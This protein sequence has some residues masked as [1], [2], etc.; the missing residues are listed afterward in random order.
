M[1]ATRPPLISEGSVIDGRFELLRLVGQGGFATVYE[2]RQ[3]NIGRKVAVKV[4]SLQH[5]LRPEQMDG[6]KERFVQ[7]ARAA[8]GIHHPDIVTIHDY[9]VVDQQP[10]IV[11]ELLQGHDLGQEIELHGALSPARAIPLFIRCLDALQAAHDQTIVHKDLKPSNLFLTD[12]GSMVETLRILDFGIA[13]VLDPDDGESGRMTKTGEYVGTAMYCAPEYYD[14]GTVSPALDVYQMGLILAE[15]LTGRAVVDDRPVRAIMRH[16]DGDV[17]CP[18]ELRGSPIEPLIDRAMARQPRDRFPNAGAFRDA[19]A[20]INA[21][22]IP[23][24]AGAGIVSTEAPT[25]DE[26]AALRRRQAPRQPTGQPSTGSTRPAARMAVPGTPTQPAPA[27]RRAATLPIVAASGVFVVLAVAVAIWLVAAPIGGELDLPPRGPVRP[28]ASAAVAAPAVPTPEVAEK[29]TTPA[30]VAPAADPVEVVPTPKPARAYNVQFFV[31]ASK[32]QAKVEWASEGPR[33][34]PK[35]TW[36]FDPAT[37]AP[38]WELRA[39]RRGYKTLGLR[40]APAA[41]GDHLVIQRG[42]ANK[43]GFSWD[44]TGQTIN[45]TLDGSF[46]VHAELERKAARKKGS[47]FID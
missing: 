38:P 23:D 19:L 12:V 40:I 33:P 6:F 25:T 2:A 4:L 46:E 28:D 44:E 34:V 5:D 11:M 8:A 22:Q 42:E 30:E 15:M 27:Q 35:G 10:Y 17:H 3:I 14:E 13:A 9:G 31:V 47:S 18:E 36:T 26:S 41:D 29:P 7:E 1:T 21:A 45:A 24:H 39:S 16:I 20:L 32:R 37:T 43:N